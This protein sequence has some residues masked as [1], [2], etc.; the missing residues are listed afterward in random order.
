MSWLEVQWNLEIFVFFWSREF[1]YSNKCPVNH[2]ARPS[3]LKPTL[4]FFIKS[5]KLEI[6]FSSFRKSR[7]WSTRVPEILL[8]SFRAKS[9]FFIAGLA[10]AL[11]FEFE[12]FRREIWFFYQ[13][14]GKFEII[15]LLWNIHFWTGK[16]NRGEKSFFC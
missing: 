7:G 3:L 2:W 11:T 14:G 1:F 5:A 15:V 13:Y 12:N 10:I 8:I 16:F 9:T 4:G 6:F